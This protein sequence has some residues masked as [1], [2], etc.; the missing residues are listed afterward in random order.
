M[1]APHQRGRRTGR[2]LDL[3]DL[4]A[5]A[6]DYL[7][8]YASSAANLRRVLRNK[9]ER[10][11]R[12][13]G[14]DREAGLAAVDALVERLAGSGVLD[15]RRFAEARARS[16]FQRGGSRRAIAGK[17]ASKGVGT[18]DTVAALDGLAE[19]AADPE[20]EAACAFAKRR[21]LGPFRDPATRAAWRDKDLAALGRAGFSYNL[22]RRVVDAVDP[23][24]LADEAGE[25]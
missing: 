13:H 24:A 12:L 10:S 6:V 3:E 15:D 7:A 21:R 20:L 8:R 18:E 14:T 4:E 1:K 5:R 22:A 16:L 2:P 19:L 25:R 17:L 11:A 9:V 23:D